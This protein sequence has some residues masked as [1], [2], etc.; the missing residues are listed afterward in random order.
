MTTLH[1]AATK[2]LEALEVA[3]QWESDGD[4]DKPFTTAI[5]AL[6]AALAQQ[7]KFTNDLVEFV[8]D[9]LT[10]DKDHARALMSQALA[11]QGE[12]ETWI[13]DGGWT[14]PVER[15]IIQTR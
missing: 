2:A 10:V 13:D 1:E 9:A 8:A 12:P 6:K 15:Q 14:F 3:Q 5:E 7:P 4:P 11:Q